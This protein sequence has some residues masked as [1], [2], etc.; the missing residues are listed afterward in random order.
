MYTD[1]TDIKKYYEKTN[2]HHYT[3]CLKT[4]MIWINLHE[5][6]IYQI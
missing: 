4:E 2:R 1:I 3:I 6:I 5:V